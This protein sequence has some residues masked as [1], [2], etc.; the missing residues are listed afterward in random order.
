MRAWSPVLVLA[1]AG[2]GSTNPWQDYTQTDP[3]DSTYERSVGA[4]R[5]IIGV[6]ATGDAAQV[7]AILEGALKEAGGGQIAILGRDDG[8]LDHAVG[9]GGPFQETPL[10][11]K[12]YE[13]TFR[14]VG[15]DPQQPLDLRWTGDPAMPPTMMRVTGDLV[16]V[17][18][19]GQGEFALVITEKAGLFCGGKDLV[20]GRAGR[21]L[22][23]RPFEL[24]VG[25]K[26]VAVEVLSDSL[27]VDAPIVLYSITGFGGDVRALVARLVAQQH[28][29][30]AGVTSIDMVETTVW[31]RST[32][33]TG[34][35]QTP[36]KEGQ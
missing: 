18:V 28:H 22:R 29:S 14:A 11:V 6:Q 2:C 3:V 9:P 27:Q 32:S 8:Q 20:R 31:L 5:L 1:L 19:R 34:A 35:A 13:A 26:P 24:V 12:R 21:G 17:T 16:A 23:Q 4:G 36:V 15:L 30:A 25:G 7:L 10:R 33:S